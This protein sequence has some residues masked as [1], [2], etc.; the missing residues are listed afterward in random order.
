MPFI[1]SNDHTSL[2][3][4]DWGSGEPVVFV[5]GWCLSS[6]MWEYQ[7]VPLA[8]AGFRCVSYDVRGCGRS[9]QPGGGYDLDTLA[10]D[11]AAVI[12]GL[13]LR[14]A[15][16]VGHSAGSAQ[17]LRY[18]SRHGSA[19]VARISL[20]S[21]TAPYLIKADDN[22]NGVDGAVLEEMISGL[23]ADRQRWAASLAGPWFGVRPDGMPLSQ[24]L[25]DWAVGIFLQASPRAAIETIRA[26]Y[27]TDLRPDA[28]GT[29]VPTLIVHGDADIMVPFEISARR[30]VEEM[31][32][33][34]LKVY[35]NASHGPFI[36]HKER[37]NDDLLTFLGHQTKAKLS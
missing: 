33:A 26:V 1:S 28:R 3:Y 6:E 36:S 18:L 25:L 5:P 30:L 9:D 35:E 32:R 16:L 23:R 12:E 19:R 21:S 2:Y 13:G 17:I 27:T 14:D 24:E 10:D 8:E 20:I 11:L 34:E 7:M 15:A 22:P 4:K 37:L 31:P 29:T